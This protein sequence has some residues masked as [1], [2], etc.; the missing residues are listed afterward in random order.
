MTGS[1]RFIY[2]TSSG[3]TAASTPQKMMVDPFHLI[4]LNAVSQGKK[5]NKSKG[6]Q[7]KRP[8]ISRSS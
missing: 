6:A 7:T 8:S 2:R 1:H 3:T 5:V 4:R